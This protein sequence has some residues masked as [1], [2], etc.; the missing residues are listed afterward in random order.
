M[1]DTNKN[2]VGKVIKVYYKADGKEHMKTG[3]VISQG[4]LSNGKPKMSMLLTDGN[5]WLSSYVNVE[6][7]TSAR[8][9][10][11]LRAALTQYY[12]A[13]T[14]QETFLQTFWKE[15]G[16]HEQNVSASLKAV[17]D[18]SGSMS[19][20]EFSAAVEKLFKD[21]FPSE[22]DHSGWYKKYFHCS[23]GCQTEISIDHVQDIEKYATPEKYSF[24]R[25]RY[26]DTLTIESDTPGFQQF[27]ER[28]AP[29]VIPSLKG[30]CKTEVDANIG[31]KWLTVCRTYTLPLTNGYNK[32]SLQDLKA[33]LTAPVKSKLSD[34]ISSAEKK[35]AANNK[36][37]SGARSK[38]DNHER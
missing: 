2:Y 35:K 24:I 23:G 8:I 6:K 21:T 26:D 3:I 16:R 18:C 38:K 30:K 34:R 13:K 19:Y 32:E 9:D 17:R 37:P 36:T 28:N 10:E 33:L 29:P 31:D 15:K 20:N 14:E 22:E 4:T 5:E 1:N 27:C 11:N 7:I 12:K 25:R